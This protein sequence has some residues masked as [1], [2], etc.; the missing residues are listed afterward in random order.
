MASKIRSSHPT[1]NL[2]RWLESCSPPSPA[3]GCLLSC[4]FRKSRYM[5]RVRAIA[6]GLLR[7]RISIIVRFRF[8]VP[9][10]FSTH[11]KTLREPVFQVKMASWHTIITENTKNWDW[12]RHV[13]S[14]HRT[15]YV[16]FLVPFSNISE[17]NFRGVLTQAFGYHT[18]YLALR[19]TSL[20]RTRALEPE[21]PAANHSVSFGAWCMI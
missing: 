17:R 18:N 8:Y 19:C 1:R 9:V 13:T 16:Q 7:R 15:L 6:I 20:P 12:T 3:P 21:W 2:S 4:P 10:K 14:H 11:Q 5:C